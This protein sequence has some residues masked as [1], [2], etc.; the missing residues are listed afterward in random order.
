[1]LTSNLRAVLPSSL[2]RSAETII[3]AYRA[4]GYTVTEFLS[5]HEHNSYRPH[6]I[7]KKGFETIIFE[8]REKCNVEKH[9]ENFV[10]KSQAHRVPIK[11]YF[12]MPEYIDD[13]ESTVGIAQRSTLKKLGIG[14]MIVKEGE[15]IE[16][17]G[18]ISCNRRFVIEPGT[19]LG[20][21]TSQVHEIIEKYNFGN[22]LDAVRDLCEEVEDAT[23]L[24]ALKAARKNKINLTVQEINDHEEDWSGLINCL[25]FRQWKN[26]PQ[27]QIITDRRLR[28]SLH[29]FRDKR[30]LSDHRKTA[31]Q[32]RDLE[33]QYPEAMLQGIRLLRKLVTINNGLR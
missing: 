27:T 29:D 24:L 6:L 14:L 10:D 3:T 12:A 17:L 11:I 9:F 28:A 2:W 4:K 20:K 33:Q 19:S 31:R 21:H 26:L 23:T 13:V 25:S 30:N 8:L 32:L 15:V 5:V 7:C 1:M 18:T 16:D 22:C